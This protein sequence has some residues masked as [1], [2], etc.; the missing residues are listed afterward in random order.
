MK[1]ATG[2]FVSIVLNQLSSESENLSHMKELLVV[3]VTNSLQVGKTGRAPVAQIFNCKSEN[4]S[5]KKRATVRPLSVVTHWTW[6]TEDQGTPMCT[7]QR[8]LTWEPVMTL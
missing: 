5:C 1:R 8:G 2:S 6:T 4:L 7:L 3:R